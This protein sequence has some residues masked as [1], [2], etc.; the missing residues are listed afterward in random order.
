MQKI[1]SGHL[2]L[3]CNF[4][5]SSSDAKAV[6][7]IA[8]GFG[9]HSG[10]YLHLIDFLLASG[11]DV[12][13]FDFR[14]HGKSEGQRGCINSFE[15]Y[16]EDLHSAVTAVKKQSLAKKIFLMGHS[17]GGLISYS[18]ASQ[19]PNAVDALVVSCPLFATKLRV[20]L[21]KKTIANALTKAVPCFAL[22]SGI[23]SR[24][25]TKDPYFAAV[26]D[27]DPTYL[28]KVT[29][30]WF[31]EITYRM[32]NLQQLKPNPQIPL[33]L[34]LAEEDLLTDSEIAQKWFETLP[35]AMDKQ[36]ICYPNFLHALFHEKDKEKP[37]SDLV[38]WL[39]IKQN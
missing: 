5:H 29:A 18:Y 37:M 13:S 35:E 22:S 11:F 21:W 12:F 31:S 10:Y 27:K 20:P 14:G 19:T 26:Y 4:E 36:I 34:M 6:V 15:D 2:Q 9:E 16:L 28:R 23:S 1:T 17:M 24:I 7:L 25:L 3:H 38:T 33:L 8:H 30:R 32:E 39:E